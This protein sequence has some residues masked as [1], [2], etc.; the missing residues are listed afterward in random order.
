MPKHLSIRN[1]LLGLII[2][3]PLGV[4]GYNRLGPVLRP[5]TN[6]ERS[7]LDRLFQ[8]LGIRRPSQV[9]EPVEFSLLDINGRTVSL[10]DFRGK[11]VFLNFWATW[12]PA[13]RVEMPAMEKLHQKLKTKDFA[14]VTVSLHETAAEVKQYFADNHLTFMALVDSTGAVGYRL[15]IRSIPTTVILDESGRIIGQALGP[16]EWNDKAAVALFE[17]LIAQRPDPSTGAASS[18]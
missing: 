15:G 6:V 10:S 2:L 5:E 7:R 12:C 4:L 11:I 14:M 16:R 8:E 17:R 18:P 1:L 3:V 9:T 13:C